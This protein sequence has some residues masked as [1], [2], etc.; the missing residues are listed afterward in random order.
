MVMSVREAPEGMKRVCLIDARTADGGH[1]PRRKRGVCV[2]VRAFCGKSE[3]EP[4]RV[5]PAVGTAAGPTDRSG[6]SAQT[7][8]RRAFLDKS[9][10]AAIMAV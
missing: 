3:G 6:N 10:E 5:I 2:F 1:S 4:F 7:L 8:A 9:A